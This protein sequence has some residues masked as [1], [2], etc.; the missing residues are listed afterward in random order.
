MLVALPANRQAKLL[1]LHLRD[2]VQLFFQLLTLAIRQNWELPTKAITDRFCN[3]QLQK[4]RVLKLENTKFDSEA[5]TV[6]NF[7]GLVTKKTAKLCPHPDSAASATIDP[8][9]VDAVVEK[10]RFD[11]DRVSRSEITLSAQE[12]SSVQFRRQFIKNMPGWLRANL[13]EQFEGTT[14]E[15]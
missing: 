3:P 1:H 13:L 5:D 2:A 9:A 11:Q 4:I 8:H 6:H 15:N 14:V 12:G 7:S 10:A